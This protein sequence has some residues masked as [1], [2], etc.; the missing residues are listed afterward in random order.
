[1]PFDGDVREHE[2]A[3]VKILRGAK[4][5]LLTRGWCRGSMAEDR[6]GASVPWYDPDAVAFCSL[7]A[8][9]RARVEV[10]PSLPCEGRFVE[11][12][13]SYQDAISDLS[14]ALGNWQHGIATFN[15]TARSRDEVVAA[16]D[17]AIELAQ[18]KTHAV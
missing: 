15:D 13:S 14:R 5:L 2:P 7:G 11:T 17:R 6:D 16:F 1:M 4:Q 8:L 18:E 12:D 10:A 3:R 9:S